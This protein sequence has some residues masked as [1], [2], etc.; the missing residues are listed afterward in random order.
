MYDSWS[1][2]SNVLKLIQDPVQANV[3]YHSGLN[4]NWKNIQDPGPMSG[5]NNEHIT[6]GTA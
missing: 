5:S 2:N 6:E 1:D 3:Y 4:L